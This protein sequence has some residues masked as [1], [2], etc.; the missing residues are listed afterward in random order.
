MGG[1]VFAC[2]GGAFGQTGL[3]HILEVC[4]SNLFLENLIACWQLVGVWTQGFIVIL[5]FGTGV[6]HSLFIN[7]EGNV[8]SCGSGEWGQLGL[9]QPGVSTSEEQD[10]GDEDFVY[11]Q[12][13]PREIHFHPPLFGSGS[14]K[15]VQVAAGAR[16]SPGIHGCPHVA[17][18]G[19]P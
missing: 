4:L 19:I 9:V 11:E 5:R 12:L 17:W 7:E 15:I 1:D 6:V 18:V 8:L 14:L 13:V 16:W 2:G 10:L 3:G